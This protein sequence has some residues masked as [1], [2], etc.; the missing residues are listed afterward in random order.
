MYEKIQW[1]GIQLIWVVMGI[2]GAAIGLGSLPRMTRKQLWTAV[3]SGIVFSAMA[4]QWANHAYVHWLPTWVNASGAPLP[5]F[6]SGTIAFVFGIGG[7][8]IVP[9]IIVF[10]QGFSTDP[11]GWF[12]KLMDAINRARGIPVPPDSDHKEQQ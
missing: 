1:E 3:A 10:W 6:M 5:S 11:W 2:F 7:M 4:P 12:H 8:F 9:G